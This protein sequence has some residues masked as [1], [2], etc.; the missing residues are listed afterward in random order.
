MFP[1]PCLCLAALFFRTQ[2]AAS[3]NF[4]PREYNLTPLHDTLEASLG[5]LGQRERERE[6]HGEGKAGGEGGEEGVEGECAFGVWLS[7]SESTLPATLLT[8]VY[9]AA[10]STD[11][12]ALSSPR[13]LAATAHFLAQCTVKKTVLRLS[14]HGAPRP[15]VLHEYS[16]ESPRRRIAGAPLAPARGAPHGLHESP[17]GGPVYQGYTGGE[18]RAGPWLERL[19]WGRATPWDPL[20]SR[21]VLCHLLHRPSPCPGAGDPTP[22]PRGPSTRVPSHRDA[23][24]RAHSSKLQAERGPKAAQVLQGQSLERGV[25]ASAATATA[26]ADAVWGRSVPTRP[27]AARPVSAPEAAAMASPGAPAPADSAAPAA[28]GTAAPAPADSSAP[29][30]V[31][32]GAPSAVGGTGMALAIATVGPTAGA[33]QP[34]PQHK[35]QPQPQAQ[36][37]HQPQAQVTTIENLPD[38]LLVEILER[39]AQRGTSFVHALV[40]RRWLRTSLEV[41]TAMD[42]QGRPARVQRRHAGGAGAASSLLTESALVSQAASFANLTRLRLGAGS[43]RELTDVFLEGLGMHCRSL[44]ELYVAEGATRRGCRFLSS[45]LVALVCGNPG[46]VRIELLDCNE[47]PWMVPWGITALGSL[48]VLRLGSVDRVGTQI[49]TLPS[50]FGD[51]SSLRALSLH[52]LRLP[53]AVCR[54]PA[55]QELSIITLYEERLNAPL[56]ELQQ[57]KVLSISNCF[58][59]E[60]LPAS[61]G[62]LSML[63]RLA[64]RNA[65]SLVSLPAQLCSLPGL[66]SLS[67]SSCPALGSLPEN[68][69]DLTALEALSID[70]CSALRAL[71]ASITQLTNLTSLELSHCRGLL[72]LPQDIHGL[73]NLRKLTLSVLDCVQKLPDNLPS[74]SNLM[75]LTLSSCPEIQALPLF[76]GWLP[77]LA[78]LHIS[79]CPRL[80]ELPVSLGMLTSLTGLHLEGNSLREVPESVSKLTNLRDLVVDQPHT[81]YL[82]RKLLSIRALSQESKQGL[83]ELLAENPDL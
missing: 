67:L 22:V 15:W 28:T 62:S 76:F 74:L 50:T 23:V 53:E 75:D 3:A 26:A 29:A 69:G 1:P 77:R 10:S 31:D 40:S 57:L 37:Q 78:R 41:Q 72:E 12:H 60:H 81:P 8:E 11:R 65:F 35:P 73:V 14:V 82:S 27:G 5:H 21:V 25:A 71:P 9:Q 66:L 2:Q 17:P 43:V 56:W 70:R 42:I 4:V 46:L 32:S 47:G 34:Q 13:H 18:P 39:V 7:E 19:E 6:E 38:A 80:S 54:L 59:L 51:L 58:E 55:L 20:W 52:C 33:L 68:L 30:A 79:H 64:L 24:P 61:I 16:L 49:A 44:R 83:R 48:E 45:G 63:Q 36:P